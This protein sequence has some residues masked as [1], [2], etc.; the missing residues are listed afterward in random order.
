MS[1]YFEVMGQSIFP[2]CPENG[3]PVRYWSFPKGA[4][5]PETQVFDDSVVFE[6]S[7][8]EWILR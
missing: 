8:A 6:R 1:E 5:N 2:D 7:E 3:E 4:Y